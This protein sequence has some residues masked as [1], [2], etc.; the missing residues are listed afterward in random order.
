MSTELLRQTYQGLLGPAKALQ[1][2]HLP[3]IQSRARTLDAG[4]VMRLVK[5]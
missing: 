1:E 2:R 5:G 4:E 3:D